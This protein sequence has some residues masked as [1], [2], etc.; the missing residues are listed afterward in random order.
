MFEKHMIVGELL[1][2]WFIP[3]VNQFEKKFLCKKL[4]EIDPEG[5]RDELWSLD[6]VFV[7]LPVEKLSDIYDA[8]ENLMMSAVG[9]E[10]DALAE[11]QNPQWLAFHNIDPLHALIAREFVIDRIECLKKRSNYLFLYHKSSGFW[12][13]MSFPEAEEQFQ[14]D[15][16][17]LHS[18]SSV[19]DDILFFFTLE[20]AEK[21]VQDSKKYFKHDDEALIDFWSEF[22][23]MWPNREYFD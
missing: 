18:L 15:Q 21:Y 20:E 9:R 19:G 13:W 23:F 8:V 17:T 2:H 10:E 14:L 5:Y 12:E 16:Q 11:L 6:T 4:D 1:D 3:Q 7:D 22:R